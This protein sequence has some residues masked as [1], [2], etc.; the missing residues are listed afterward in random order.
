M[1]H[2]YSSTLAEET[3]R[4]FQAYTDLLDTAEWLKGEL[5]GPLLSFDLAMGEFRLLE[6]LHP[7]GAQFM[8]DIA[9]KRK[10]HRQAVD[11]AVRRGLLT[12]P[13]RRILAR[14]ER[15]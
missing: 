14:R 11:V 1:R 9:R 2:A 15:R 8:P 4:A 13:R 12:G 10:L 7:E 3:K 5:R 6:L